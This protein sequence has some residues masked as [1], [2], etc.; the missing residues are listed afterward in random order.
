MA[1]DDSAQPVPSRRPLIIYLAVQATLLLTSVALP[2]IPGSGVRLAMVLGGTIVFLVGVARRR[3][4]PWVAWWFVAAGT[5]LEVAASV[6]VA[7][8]YGSGPRSNIAGAAPIVLAALVLPAIAIGFVLL[9]RASPYGGTADIL[10]ATV[11]GIAGFLLVWTF[12]VEPTLGQGRFNLAAGVTYSIGMLVVLALTAK[13][14]FGGG[15]QHGALRLLLCAMMLLLASSVLLLLPAVTNE[16]ITSNRAGGILRACYGAVL[17]AVG[18]HPAL[19]E[20]RSR[21]GRTLLAMSPRRIALYAVFALVTPTAWAVQLADSGAEITHNPGGF[22][23][24]IGASAVLLVLVVLRLTLVARLAQQ[25]TSEL[26]RRSAALSTAVGE[27]RELQQQ[28]AYRAGHDPLTGLANRAVLLDRLDGLY[29]RPGDYGEHGMLMLDLDGF[30]DINDTLGHPTGDELLAEVGRRLQRAAPAGATLAR[31]G[32]DEFVVLLEN[33]SA[34]KTREWAEKALAAVEQVYSIGGRE[35]FLTASVGVLTTGGDLPRPTPSEMLRDADLAM[36]AAKEAGRNRIMMFKPEF[37]AARLHQ[38][39]VS[40]ALRRALTEQEFVLHYQPIVELDTRRVR[41]VEALLRW[42]PPGAGLIT[43]AE[44]I[45]IAEGNGLIVPIGTWVL[46]TALSDA[47][48]WYLE[49]HISVSVNVSGRQLDDPGFTDIVLRALSGA[50]LP[51]DALILEI[52]ES[53]LV[54]SAHAAVLHQHLRRLREA[55][56]RVAVDDFGTGYSSLSYVSDLPI[57]IVKIDKAFTRPPSGPGGSPQDWAFTKAILE[58]VDSLQMLAIAEGVE[59]V[60]QAD[61]LRF[62]HCPLVQG[63]LFARPVPAEAIDRTL[64]GPGPSLIRATGPNPHRDHDEVAG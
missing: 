5:V 59:T 13:L 48:R 46:E 41:A 15:L 12:A 22:W 40:S 45:P 17:G 27:Q 54:T 61:A 33:T 6:T 56:V 14:A 28:L 64:A 60:E 34:A 50:D 1:E 32:G 36:Y 44:F 52:T 30:K 9:S 49:H 58:L 57:D 10:D 23:A 26:A 11:T 4:T 16:A 37:R 38:T 25:R 62:L 8:V 42:H 21:T 29:R 24:P 31:L 7:G 51:G 18:L 2:P 35:M 19:G 47:R 3:P 55:G 53:T 20:P 39:R 63:Y 43:P